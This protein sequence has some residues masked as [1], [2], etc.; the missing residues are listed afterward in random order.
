MT[1]SM[2]G[3]QTLLQQ[4]T[5][6]TDIELSLSALSTAL[7]ACCHSLLRPPLTR[8]ALPATRRRLPA[9]HVTLMSARADGP[10]GCHPRTAR[11]AP[12]TCPIPHAV[13]EPSRGPGGTRP[14]TRPPFQRPSSTHVATCAP[15]GPHSGRAQSQRGPL[16]PPV[17]RIYCRSIRFA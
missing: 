13:S 6:Q 3:V 11:M 15:G 1:Q 7:S 10:P 12:R 17:A 16:A 4:R 9:L 8:A 2:T 5:P 14:A